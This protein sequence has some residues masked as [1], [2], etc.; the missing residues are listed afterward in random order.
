MKRINRLSM[1]LLFFNFLSLNTIKMP[2]DLFFDKSNDQLS[3][4]ST[5]PLSD[6]ILALEKGLQELDQEVKK[7]NLAEQ[8]DKINGVSEQVKAQLEKDKINEFY[9]LKLS[10]Y[11]KSYQAILEIEQA[12][13]DA[14]AIIEQH[15]G[16]LKEFQEDPQFNKLR[17]ERKTYYSFDELQKIGN[18]LQEYEDRLVSIQDK[19]KT[20]NTELSSRKKK[21]SVIDTDL[22]NKQKQREEL[23]QGL[24]IGISSSI[25]PKDQGEIVDIQIRFLELKK[26]AIQA[27][28]FEAELRIAKLDSQR[29]ILMEQVRLLKNEYA[30]VKAGV[31]VDEIYVKKLQATLDKKRTESLKKVKRYAENFQALESLHDELEESLTAASHRFQISTTEL[32]LADWTIRQNISINEWIGNLL[33]TKIHE[34]ILTYTVNKNL[35]QAQSDLEEMKFNSQE[36]LLDIVES[37][38]K[39]TML[40]NA[41]DTDEELRAEIKKYDGPRSELETDLTSVHEKLTQ[42]TNSLTTLHNALDETKL[43]KQALKKQ[44]DDLFKNNDE[45]FQQS[46]QII[47]D[48]EETLRS[49]IDATAKLVE[50]YSAQQNVVSNSLKEVNHIVRELNL[51]DFWQPSSQ[52]IDWASEM[53][54]I[55]P[56]IKLFISDLQ[57]LGSSY[58]PSLLIDTFVKKVKDLSHNF[59]QILLLIINLTLILVLFLLFKIYIPEARVFF[60]NVEKVPAGRYKAALFVSF[61]LGFLERYLFF[62][63]SWFIVWFLIQINIFYDIYFIILFSLI[64][65]PLYIFLCNRFFVEFSSFNAENEYR[66]LSEK[67]ENRFTFVVSW[68]F[69]ALTAILFFRYAFMLLNYHQSN[70]PTVLIAIAIILCQIAAIFLIGRE[71]ILRLIPGKT[72]FWSWFKQ[73]IDKYYFIMVFVLIG[74]IVMSNPFVGFFRQVSYI[75]SRLFITAVVVPLFL[76]LHNFL[77]NRSSSLFFYTEGESFK[78]RFPYAN[79]AYGLMVIATFI[80]FLIVS[81]LVLSRVWGA[82][83]LLEDIKALLDKEIMPSPGLYAEK[84]AIRITSWS[85]LQVFAYVG[86]GILLVFFINRMVLGRLFDLLLVNV[87]VQNTLFTLTRYL[88][89]TMAFLIGLHSVHLGYLINYIGAALLALGFA[90]KDPISDVICYFVILVQ[91]PIKIGDFINLGDEISGVVRQI[92]PRSVILR[93]KNSVTLVVPNSQ[94]IT[95][96]IINWNYTPTYFAFSDIF[97]T[98]V[99]KA[100]PKKARDLMLKVLDDYPDIL[101]SP[102]PVIRLKNF[103]E[104][105]YQFMVRGF[106][107]ADKTLDQWDIQSNVRLEIVKTLREH[108]IEIAIPV[109]TIHVSSEGG[110]PEEVF[111]EPPSD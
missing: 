6:Q 23:L 48:I 9:A 29:H 90:I 70:L 34:E 50:T 10:V 22:K 25:D 101:K 21:L 94:F 102:A 60:S 81:V 71:Q 47:V 46:A 39:M 33:I 100:D 41:I 65:I 89:I 8:L 66:F 63:Y 57:A 62:I 80:V 76:R 61:V 111:Q 68:L 18:Q 109:R 106:L 17:I 5:T 45:S 42:A 14:R 88:V 79:A 27:K 73:L 7:R 91:R 35:I 105:G 77:K 44:K 82:P 87:G 56:D 93:K 74:V 52:A 2:F 12:Y 97:I 108:N 30:R 107:S 20:A 31:R 78:E 1:A 104:N 95:K 32:P 64:S 84:Q 19:A 36:I 37:W 96:P 11:N 98:I 67:Y 16:V 83:I 13:K 38:H 53:P 54:R 43:K 49:R 72:E 99:Y 51:K 85:L 75:V 58:L 110:Q 59:W 4:V 40:K 15:K 3:H 26:E 103:T 55:L 69:Y 86:F 24:D 28:I 92:T